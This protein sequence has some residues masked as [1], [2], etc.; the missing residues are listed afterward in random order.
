[1]SADRKIF[2]EQNLP[3]NLIQL[4]PR[5][6]VFT[7]GVFDVLHRGHVEYLKKAAELGSTLVVGLNS[8]SS[9]K[10]LGKGPDRPLNE[11][12]DR[13]ILLAALEC[14]SRIILFNDKNPVKLISKLKPDVYVKGG[15]YR[16]DLL[17]ETRLVK[18]WGG[19]SLA[20]PF[21]NGYSTTSLVNKIRGNFS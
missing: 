4:L 18:S 16:M 8:D 13:A 9:A 5:P 11:E 14:T 6:M 12:M 20:I 10:Q 15:D 19:D 3:S 1:M 2:H 7:N 21:V 17:E